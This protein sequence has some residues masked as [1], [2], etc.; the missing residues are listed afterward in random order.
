MNTDRRVPSCGVLSSLSIAVVAVLLLVVSAPPALPEAQAAPLLPL[1][2]TGPAQFLD[3]TLMI[4]P[5]A[6]SVLTGQMFSVDVAIAAESQPVDGV[7]LTIAFDPASLLVVDELG[8]PAGEIM[9]GVAFTTLLLNS[10]D[11]V[12]GRIG[13]AA[14][15]LTGGPLQGFI[16][17]ATIRFRAL[18]SAG[19]SVVFLLPPLGH[20]AVT[21]GGENVLVLVRNGLVE[22][23]DPPTPTPTQP[24]S[25]PTNT[26]TPTQPASPP[27]NTPSA[28]ASRTPTITPTLTSTPSHTPTPTYTTTSTPTD[29]PTSTPTPTDT[30]T[31]T[32]T[33]TDTPTS[34][35]TAT[36]T[37]TE[38]STATS[39]P[40]A[41][42]SATPTASRHSAY[43]GLIMV[44]QSATAG[45]GGNP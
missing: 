18:H 17:V 24:A 22:A 29:T 40:T 41:T 19:S 20:T 32:P 31:S 8:D 37:T 33:P 15:Q 35:A 3:V 25:P 27:T 26:P 14:G 28:T 5:S 2:E 11:N 42:P 45:S 13:F 16:Q 38:T 12:A 44:N 7:Q 30:P 6:V 36:S 39:T 10:A 23:S 34:T 9:A 1:G 21:F 43:L 4:T